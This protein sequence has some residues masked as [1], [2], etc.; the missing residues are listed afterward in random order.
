MALH[1]ATRFSD[2][3]RLVSSYQRG[4]GLLAGDAAHDHSPFGGQGLK[5]GLLDAVNLGWKLAATVQRR[6]PDGLLSTYT[7][8]RHTV[9]ARALDNTRARFAVMRP[10]SQTTAMRELMAELLTTQP[11]VNRSFGE[12]LS[13]VTT[14]YDPGEE[15]PLVGRLVADAGLTVD[16]RDLACTR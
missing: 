14:R 7:S 9:A 8:E 16:G 12:M 15:D 10:D 1:P 6:A 13:G 2:T 3:S 4:R 11:D 5:V